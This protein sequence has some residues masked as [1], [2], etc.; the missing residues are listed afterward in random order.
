MIFTVCDLTGPTLAA[1]TYTN[2][3]V[4]SPN[5]P[6]NYDQN[7]DCSLTLKANQRFHVVK[8]VFKDFLLGMGTSGDC[9]YDKLEFYDGVSEF[10]TKIGTFCGETHPE[11]LYSSGRHLYVRFTSDGSSEFQGFSFYFSAVP[12]G[13]IL[14]QNASV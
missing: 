5:Y 7:E 10:D 12:A 1:L 9:N 11:V 2:N 4:T 8:V 3:T 13:E 6:L 14:C